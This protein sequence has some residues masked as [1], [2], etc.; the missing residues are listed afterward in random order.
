[1]LNYVFNLIVHCSQIHLHRTKIRWDFLFCVNG[2]Q[3]IYKSREIKTT[4]KFYFWHGLQLHWPALLRSWL[5]RKCSCITFSWQCPTWP[6]TDSFQHKVIQEESVARWS[7]LLVS[8]SFLLLT[9]PLHLSVKWCF[10]MISVSASCKLSLKS[11][12]SMTILNKSDPVQ[13]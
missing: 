11:V 5:N 4:P 9:H 10:I 1:M 2:K 8:N 12:L 3:F 7:L 6:G 13:F